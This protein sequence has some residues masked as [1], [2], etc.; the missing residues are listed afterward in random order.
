MQERF[1]AMHAVIA[2]NTDELS[3]ACEAHLAHA[4]ST[5]FPFVWRLY[6]SHRA[7]LF[8]LGLVEDGQLGL[9]AASQVARVGA[10]DARHQCSSRCSMS[11]CR[12]MPPT[13]MSIVCYVSGGSRRWPGRDRRLHGRDSPLSAESRAR[14][15]SEHQAA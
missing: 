8:G 2:P 1:S 14:H 5:D 4:G 7:A 6:R 3:E 9:T 12:R 11:A 13:S 10:R 15:P